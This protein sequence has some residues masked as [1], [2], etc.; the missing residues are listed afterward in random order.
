[1]CALELPDSCCLVLTAVLGFEREEQG[2]TLA[3]FAERL[4][5]RINKSLEKLSKDRPQVKYPNPDGKGTIAH[6]M[7]AGYYDR[8]PTMARIRFF[9]RNQKVVKRPEVNSYRPVGTRWEISMPDKVGHARGW[10]AFFLLLTAFI[11]ST[12]SLCVMI[13]RSSSNST[14]AVSCR[15]L[16][17]MSSSTR[18]A[19]RSL[20]TAG[21]LQSYG[22]GT[23]QA[24]S[25]CS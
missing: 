3:L 6:L 10:Y 5:R 21:S 25:F 4:S 2:D 15:V 12:T 17:R 14:M 13:P 1:M 18:T 23:I 8:L 7:L 11:L 22:I 20:L 19:T 9:H 16:D 24:L